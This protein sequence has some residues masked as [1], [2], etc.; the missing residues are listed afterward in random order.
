MSIL[1]IGNADGFCAQTAGIW[2]FLGYALFVLKI[3]I[4]VILIA[5]GVV[6]L[7]KAV[8]ASDDKEIKTAINSL[9]KKVITAVVI[10]FIPSIISAL[11]GLVAGFSEVKDDYNVCV[12]CITNPRN[13]ACTKYIK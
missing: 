1:A 11:F 8:I 13:E 6:A 3:L 5:L 2:Q 4:P 10:F 9:I 12:K 7:G